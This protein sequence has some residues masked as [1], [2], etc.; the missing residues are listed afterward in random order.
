MC[1]DLLQDSHAVEAIL[2]CN[3][4]AILYTTE[5]MIPCLLKSVSKPN[6]WEHIMIDV[7]RGSTVSI[8]HDCKCK[9]LKYV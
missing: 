9:N 5:Y 6:E 3:E 1:I 2:S 4:R 8:H 7:T